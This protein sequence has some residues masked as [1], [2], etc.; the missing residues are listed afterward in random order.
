MRKNEE[1]RTWKMSRI[2]HTMVDILLDD[3][4]EISSNEEALAVLPIEGNV[5]DG[6]ESSHPG[7]RHHVGSTRTWERH[8]EKGIG[9]WGIAQ[10]ADQRP[11]EKRG[12]ASC[13]ERQETDEKPLG[14]SCA[15]PG[16]ALSLPE[17]P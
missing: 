10:C 4:W 17:T 15:A 12:H 1:E 16:E 9:Q 13:A 6:P 7:E 14:L 3:K 11:W 8:E 2:T 5:G